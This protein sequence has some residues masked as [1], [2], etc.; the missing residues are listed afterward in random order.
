MNKYDFIPASAAVIVALVMFLM[1]IFGQK[2]GNV[3]QIYTNNVLTETINLADEGT[4][5]IYDTSGNIILT[6][7]IKNRA[8]DVVSSDCDNKLCVNQSAIHR[9]GESIVCLPQKIVLAIKSDE[10]EEFDG[11]TN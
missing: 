10:E 2:D 11:F 4:Y 5:N 1:N 6:Y 8:V 9:D 3:C 7:E